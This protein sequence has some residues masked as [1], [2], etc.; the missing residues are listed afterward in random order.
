MLAKMR[1][2]NIS[3][4]ADSVS[5]VA[6]ERLLLAISYIKQVSIGQR[7]IWI[8]IEDQFSK[9]KWSIFTRRKN[10]MAGEVTEFIKRMKV[11]GIT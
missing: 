10:E 7:N 3:K 11:N 5:K 1:K 9:M 4:I 8:I 6:G 2:K